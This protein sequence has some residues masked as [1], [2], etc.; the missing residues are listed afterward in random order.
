MSNR[1]PTRSRQPVRPEVL[2]RRRLIFGLALLIAV[3]IIWNLIS[4]VMSFFAN[5]TSGSISAPA[6]N[7]SVVVECEPGMVQI[8]AGI[9]DGLYNSTNSVA[10]GENPFLWF[11]MTNNSKVACTFD[12]GSLVSFYQIKSGDQLIWDSK[13][14]DR[15]QDVSAI[16]ILNPGQSVN[17]PSSTWLRVF[18]SITGCS[19]GQKPAV[20][21]G[22]T[23]QLRAIVNGVESSVVQF[24]LN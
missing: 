18:S 21:G 20:A 2:R 12:A 11:N 19:T 23:Y 16:G 15:S 10:A 14:C 8:L 17:S 24:A 13:Q 4:G 7:Q 5:L 6:A 22:A 3:V 1:Q 9:G